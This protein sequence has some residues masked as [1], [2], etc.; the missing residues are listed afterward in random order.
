MQVNSDR[1]MAIR[2]V[3]GKTNPL[4]KL[5]RLVASQARK[6]P[7][8][9]VLAEGTR[10][11]EEA[12]VSG[13]PVESILISER[14]GN[15]PRERRLMDRILKTQAKIWRAADAIF[16]QASGVRTPQ[17]IIALVQIPVLG[18][19]DVVL[20][21]KPL[22]LCACGIQDPGNLGTLVRTAAA[23]GVSLVCSLAGTVSARNPKTVRASAGALFRVQVVEQVSAP[24]FLDFCRRR[25]IALLSSSPQGE[26]CYSDVDL[27]RA[28]ALLVG[29]EGR[30]LDIS[31]WKGATSVRIPMTSTV[32][33]LNVSAAGAILL[34]EAF[35]Q[36]SECGR[37]AQVSYASTQP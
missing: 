10:S 6:A 34:F 25:S 7:A 3:T 36:R 23:A 5:I 14:Y 8:D 33:S 35:R 32:E 11:V 12:M 4:I 15:D 31:V 30:G 29:N 37:R 20:P 22:V 26:V 1:P 9:I 28:C 17:G 2:P 13:L 16:N 27:T 21:D 24:E 18:M 19:K